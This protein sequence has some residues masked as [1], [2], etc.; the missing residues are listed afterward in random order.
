[1][2][3]SIANLLWKS[4]FEKSFIFQAVSIKMKISRILQRL[5]LPLFKNPNG[6]TFVLVFLNLFARLIRMSPLTY[7][8]LEGS[9]FILFCIPLL[10]SANSK[11]I[12]LLNQER[13]I[14]AVV[15]RYYF[16]FIFTTCRGGEKGVLAL[17]LLICPGIMLFGTIQP[18]K[19]IFSDWIFEN[20][21]LKMSK[22][23][24]FTLLWLDKGIY[25]PFLAQKRKVSMITV[26]VYDD[27]NSIALQAIDIDDLEGWEFSK[28]FRAKSSG[29]MKN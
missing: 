7:S 4:Y 11:V 17:P 9:S 13:M 16:R 27:Y 6:G 24:F 12:N 18:L 15:N 29:D 23:T 1:M 20:F 10:P 26:R 25:Y 2:N 28:K 3:V 5:W 22:N 14:Y 21:R 8:T 19:I